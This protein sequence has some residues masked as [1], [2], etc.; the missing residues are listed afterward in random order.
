MSHTISLG[1]AEK[2]V[3]DCIPFSKAGE[4]SEQMYPHLWNEVSAG[5]LEVVIDAET[6]AFSS[7][8]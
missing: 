1:K 7:D 8:P 5:N 2:A 4:S 6:G 3:G